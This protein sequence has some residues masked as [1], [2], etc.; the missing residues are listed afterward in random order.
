MCV[1]TWTLGGEHSEMAVLSRRSIDSIS[2]REQERGSARN[3][4]P[5]SAALATVSSADAIVTRDLEDR[6]SGAV[7]ELRLAGS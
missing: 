3:N 6:R 4:E 7:L 5:E 2:S 1:Q